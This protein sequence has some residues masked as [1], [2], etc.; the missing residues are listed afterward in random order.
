[1]NLDS[2]GEVLRLRGY[3]GDIPRN[4]PATSRGPCSALHHATSRYMPQAGEANDDKDRPDPSRI[5]G[6]KLGDRVALHAAVTYIGVQGMQGMQGF[7]K[8]STNT[9]PICEKFGKYPA[10]IH[11]LHNRRHDGAPE[12][13]QRLD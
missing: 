5:L 3:A 13:S 7:S 10:T 9:G 8:I 6:G 1:M 12:Y 4:S 11:T 2:C